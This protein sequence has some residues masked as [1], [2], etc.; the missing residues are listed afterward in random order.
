MCISLIARIRGFWE[1]FGQNGFL[2]LGLWL[3]NIPI[4]GM[5]VHVVNCIVN[6]FKMA[7]NG[8]ASLLLP[9]IF[10]FREKIILPC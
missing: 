7:H 3:C 2:G 9:P 1:E 6:V 8:H 5:C 10:L 4:F